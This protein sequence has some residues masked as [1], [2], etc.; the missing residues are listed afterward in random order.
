M[1]IEHVLAFTVL[2]EELNFRRAAARLYVSQP[3]L[4]AQIHGL[5]RDLGVVLFERGREGTRLTDDGT[6]LLPLARQVLRSLDD[7]ESGR[8][9]ATTPRPTTCGSGWPRTGSARRRGR[10]RAGSRR[11]DPSSTSRCGPWG[12]A[13]C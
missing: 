3:T 10:P 11:R 12:S 7:L 6:A 2:A 8:G 4:T 13:R 5:E 9:A 1:R